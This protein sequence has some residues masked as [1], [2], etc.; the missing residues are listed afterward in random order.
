[1]AER[2]NPWSVINLTIA[3][4]AGV[5]ALPFLAVAAQWGLLAIDLI[6]VTVLA[7]FVAAVRRNK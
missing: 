1:M 7:G 3:L 6:Y 5:V 4:A 2:A